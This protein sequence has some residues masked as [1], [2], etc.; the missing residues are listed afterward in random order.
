MQD[1]FLFSKPRLIPNIAYGN[2][3]MEERDVYKYAKM[4]DANGFIQR[5]P[6]G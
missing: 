3:D 4:A 2:P 5:M 6:G 1:V